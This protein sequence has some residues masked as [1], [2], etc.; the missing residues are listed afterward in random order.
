M[1]PR[2]VQVL[3]W[4]WVLV[5][6]GKPNE[7]WAVLTQG[8]LVN[9]ADLQG[10]V[11]ELLAIFGWS[12]LHVRTTVGKVRGGYKH[13]TATNVLGWPDLAPCW[14]PS[15]PGRILA[16]ELK[17]PP[18]KVSPVQAHVL[19]ELAVSGLECHVIRPDDLPVRLPQ[20]LGRERGDVPAVVTDTMTRLTTEYRELVEREIAG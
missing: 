11:V 5:Q 6:L 9:H 3:Q 18:D 1:F 2:A 7:A 10:Q 19:R 15:Q 17:V 13:L 20:L 8:H 12:H 16:L 4:A 14:N